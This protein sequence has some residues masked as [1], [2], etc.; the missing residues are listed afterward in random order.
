MSGCCS[1]ARASAQA[2]K[3]APVASE[4][5]GP[6]REVR[7]DSGSLS[8]VNETALPPLT[9]DGLVAK[10]HAPVHEWLAAICLAPQLG[11]KLPHAVMLLE[12]CNHLQLIYG[13][14]SSSAN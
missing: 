8:I 9:G 11:F 10:C 12:G 1:Q 13:S 6:L 14:A 4:V 7:R 2:R 3:L 5:C